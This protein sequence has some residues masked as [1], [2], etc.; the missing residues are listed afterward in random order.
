LMRAIIR[1]PRLEIQQEL[2]HTVTISRIRTLGSALSAP[3]SERT[4]AVDLREKAEVVRRLLDAAYPDAQCTL[5]HNGPFQL[6]IATILSAQC[7]DE[8]VNAITPDLFRRF[9]D[10]ESFARAEIHEIEDA[11]RSAGLYRSKAKNIQGACRL[12]VERHGGQVPRTLQ[13]LIHLPGIGR[14]TANVILGNAFGVPGLAV[15][16][17]VARVSGRLGLTSHQDPVRIERDLTAIFPPESWVR[18]SHQLIRH[19]RVLCHARRPQCTPCP[20][21]DLCDDYRTRP[22]RGSGG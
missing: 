8:R 9:P 17:H 18:L 6:M 1:T 12:L 21:K 7:T 16:T 22:A 20:L 19:G 10:P 11:I 13:E 14:K 3:V 5:A 4:I 2:W 15:D